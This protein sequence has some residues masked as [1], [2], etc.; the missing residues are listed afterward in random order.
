MVQGLTSSTTTLFTSPFSG[1]Y[2][3]SCGWIRAYPHTPEMYAEVLTTGVATAPNLE[4]HPNGLFRHV[5]FSPYMAF[6]LY[7]CLIYA[8]LL[9]RIVR[10][11]RRSFH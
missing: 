8:H 2:L 9:P 10:S 1:M 5:D 4:A 11:A 7:H 6:V 3:L